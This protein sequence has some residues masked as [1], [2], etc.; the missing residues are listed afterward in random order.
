MNAWVTKT[1]EGGAPRLGLTA[2]GLWWRDTSGRWA[3]TW[4]QVLGVMLLP[5]DHPERAF[6]LVPRRPPEPP[7]F[8]VRTEHLPMELRSGGLVA[9]AREIDGRLTQRGYRDMG[10]RRSRLDPDTLLRLVLERA[11]VPGALEVPVGAG[12][13]GWWRRGAEFVGGGFAGGLMGLYAGTLAGSGLVAGVGAAFGALSGAATPVLLGPNWRS[14]RE[15]RRRPRVLVLAP[16]GCVVG[17]PTGPEVFDWPSLRG[18][19]AGEEV[20]LR[21]PEEA[22]RPCLEVTRADGGVAARIDAAWFTQPL[23]LIVGV[24]EAYRRRCMRDL[25]S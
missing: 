5:Q 6:V 22:G 11:E 25:G 15:R 4:D 23:P 7:W 17:L 20:S 16:D 9:L 2:A 12:P 1:D 13:G 8:E 19:G 14:V 18:F 21:D 24:A 3:A 10:F